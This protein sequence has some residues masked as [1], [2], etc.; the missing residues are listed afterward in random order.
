MTIQATAP[1][2]PVRLYM[3][4]ITLAMFVYC[5]VGSSSLL[6]AT[7]DVDSIYSFSAYP[8]CLVP[9]M[10]EDDFSRRYGIWHVD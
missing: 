5:M 4:E 1:S 9:M 10:R 3:V 7:V 6:V 8:R 2:G